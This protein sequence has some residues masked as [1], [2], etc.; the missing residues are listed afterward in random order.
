MLMNWRVRGQGAG[1]SLAPHEAR[2]RPRFTVK[3]RVFR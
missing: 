1:H 2:A 3:E